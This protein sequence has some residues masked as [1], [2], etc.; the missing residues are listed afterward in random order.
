MD[1]MTDQVR[2]TGDTIVP[3]V[4]LGAATTIQKEQDL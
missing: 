3:C 1:D 2:T 4:A